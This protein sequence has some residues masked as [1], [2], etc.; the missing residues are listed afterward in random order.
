MRLA[1]NTIYLDCNATTPMT[2]PV[3]DVYARAAAEF[4][5]NPSSPYGAGRKAREGLELGR[6]QVASL[7]GCDSSEVVFTGSATEANYQAM[8][9][10]AMARP[11]RDRILLSAIEHP[12]IYDQQPRFRELGF[13]VE[14]IPVDQKGVVD[15]DA[16]AKTADDRVCL[17]A[18][19]TA[20]NETGVIQPVK[21]A[22]DI[23]RGVGALFLTDA[24]QAMG[25][26]P[27]PWPEARP[28]YLSIAAHKI[29]GPKGIAALICREGVPV[30]P[31][32]VGGGQEGGRRA[33][34]QSAA[35]AAAF[36][37]A[38]RQAG[39]GA[40]RF[41][42]LAAMRDDFEDGFLSSRHAVIYGR[43]SKR[44]PN[45]SFFSLPGVSGEEVVRALDFR[46]IAVGTGSACHSGSS[47]AP[48]VLRYMG[49]ALSP[50]TTPIRISLGI[51][52]TTQDMAE[53]SRALEEALK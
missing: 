20:H 3:S 18:V 36:G 2:R 47:G 27:S 1:D 52:T 49:E 45:T 12:S 25:K 44:L 29:Y 9:S 40:G 34:T 42:A 38:C 24:V 13:K 50:D 21:Q 53:F 23:A 37:E 5:G 14:E 26:I 32:L 46:G 6:A 33:S 28:D 51:D 41:A 7:V 4:F 17:I 15:M 31:L 39:D 8:L 30:T 48:R 43:E 35:L 19:M 22:A 16:L 11:E 10:A